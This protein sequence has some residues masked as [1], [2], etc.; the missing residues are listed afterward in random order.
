MTKLTKYAAII[1][2][3]LATVCIFY[4]VFIKMVLEIQLVDAYPLIVVG[5]GGFIAGV[6]YYLWKERANAD[7]KLSIRQIVIL[8]VP[9]V[10]SL[11][12]L[13]IFVLLR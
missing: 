1:V 5:A 9:I 6:I 4:F 7:A 3:Q 8:I 10:L 12:I 2:I 13:L 11:V